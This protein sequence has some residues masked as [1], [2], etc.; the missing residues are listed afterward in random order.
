MYLLP[1]ASLAGESNVLNAIA[2]RRWLRRIHLVHRDVRM[3]QL[4]FFNP[5]NVFHK[6]YDFF[7]DDKIDGRIGSADT[8]EELDRREAGS[9]SD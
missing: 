5:G 1:L 9:E 2:V 4:L 8:A 7:A 6:P 3:R